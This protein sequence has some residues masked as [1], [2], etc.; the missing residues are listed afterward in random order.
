MNSFD[1]AKDVKEKYYYDYNTQELKYILSVTQ[2]KE[3]GTQ[4]VDSIEIIL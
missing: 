1:K 3:F 2:E 4:D